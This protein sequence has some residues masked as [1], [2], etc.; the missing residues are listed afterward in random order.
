MSRVAANRVEEGHER[1]ET[2]DGGAGYDPCD[3]LGRKIGR[4]EEPVVLRYRFFP[5]ITRL[6]K[7]TSF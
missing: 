1:P 7:E 3:L 2:P 4:V 6:D 5:F